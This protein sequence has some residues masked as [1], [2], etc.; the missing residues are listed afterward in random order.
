MNTE[1]APTNLFDQ[2]SAQK[3]SHDIP[4]DHLDYKYVNQCNDVKELEKIYKT[5]VSG[6]EGKY[7]DLED[8]VFKKI[9]N[10]NPNR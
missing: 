3:K 5:L 1:Q 10:I 9:A 8:F 2:V 4:I 7:P 6:V